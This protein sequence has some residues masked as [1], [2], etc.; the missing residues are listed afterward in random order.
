[1][2]AILWHALQDADQAGTEA[3]G[4][5]PA[6]RRCYGV[7]S[8]TT[9]TPHRQSVVGHRAEH[10]V[11]H[12]GGGSSPPASTD[13]TAT[14]VSTANRAVTGGSSSAPVD[15]SSS[16]VCELQQQMHSMQ[17]QMES[18]RDVMLAVTASSISHRA[19]YVQQPLRP[20][21]PPVA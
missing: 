11:G 8:E 21:L 4:A 16:V 17:Q 14:G 18:M 20:V 12:L 10:P 2:T 19:T 7:S 9:T 5:S 13:E 15:T 1:M 3:P 6:E